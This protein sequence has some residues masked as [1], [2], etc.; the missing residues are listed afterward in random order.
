MK[1]IVSIFIALSIMVTAGVF[2]FTHTTSA[3]DKLLMEN[4]NALARDVCPE[5]AGGSG[6]PCTCIDVNGRLKCAVT[7]SGQ[8]GDVL[9][10][11][12]YCADC[13]P[14]LSREGTK[15]DSNCLP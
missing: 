11:V 6:F 15:L 2:A 8:A 7:I 4:L 9:T 13:K 12:T 14:A 3:T 1:K 5:C 10:H